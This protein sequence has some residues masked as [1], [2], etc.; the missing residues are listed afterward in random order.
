MRWIFR[1]RSFSDSDDIGLQIIVLSIF[2]HF[3]SIEKRRD[4]AYIILRFNKRKGAVSMKF[5]VADYGLNV[6]Y[7]GLYD[8]ESRLANLRELGFD[9]IERLEANSSGDALNKAALYRRCGMDFATCRGPDLAAGIQWTAGLGKEYVWLSPGPSDRKTDFSVYCR[10]ANDFLAACRRAGIRAALHNHLGSRIETQEEV[11]EF[12]K[13]CPDALLL[14]DIGHLHAAGGDVT[15]TIEKYYDRLAA[16]HFKDVELLDRGNPDWT[17]RLRFC[18][19][20]EGNADLDYTSAGKALKK[21]G[22]AKWVFIEHD[23]HLSDPLKELK[24]SLDV[25]KEIMM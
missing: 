24:V 10:R 17:K 6:W 20:G 4:D 2:S 22:F 7:G 15:G 1:K 25:M 8:L 11:D 12:M 3:F 18:G 21:R 19:L 16:V 23:T 13:E 14:L 9:G 5:G